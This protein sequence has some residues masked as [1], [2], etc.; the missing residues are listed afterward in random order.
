MTGIVSG[1]VERPVELVIIGREH[2]P[3]CDKDHDV[4]GLALRHIH[5]S[6]KAKP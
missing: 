2:C 4:Y 6:Q 3:R 1:K 5:P